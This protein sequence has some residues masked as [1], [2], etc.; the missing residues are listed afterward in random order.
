MGSQKT[1][2]ELEKKHPQKVE[3][4]DRER[5]SEGRFR[6]CGGRVFSKLLCVLLVIS[7][8]A[9]NVIICH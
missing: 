9:D 3:E 2:F 6:I 5:V 4:R 1:K 7:K 8:A